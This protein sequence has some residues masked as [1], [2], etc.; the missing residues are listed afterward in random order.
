MEAAYGLAITLTMVMTKLLMSYYLYLTK[1][2]IYLVIV[3]LL[4]YLSIEG[5]FLGANLMKFSHGGWFTILIAAVVASLMTV[6]LR[7]FYI[8]LRLTEY[9]KLESQCD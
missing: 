5:A 1:V 3:F 6:W 2:S 9:T 8:K 7:A 4:L